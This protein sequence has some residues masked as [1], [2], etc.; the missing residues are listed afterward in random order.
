MTAESTI[1]EQKRLLR[2]EAKARRDRL[3]G[4]LREQASSVIV[5]KILSRVRALPR[6]ST[7]LGYVPMR[8]EVDV[9]PA[10]AA[11]AALGYRVGIP[12]VDGRVM[13]FDLVTIDDL[14]NLVDATLGTRQ[15]PE[16]TPIDPDTVSLVIVPL[17]AFD[18]NH[19]RLGYGAGYY[20]RFLTDLRD[21]AAKRSVPPPPALGVAFA[22]QQV[23]AVPVEVHDVALDG[24]LTERT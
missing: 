2:I 8:S 7:V 9:L 15:K 21:R 16:A 1:L 3:S 18:A 13:S 11:M 24:V 12:R 19:H 17:L 5:S 22:A 6:G 23:Q 20:D 4:E 14:G 10:L